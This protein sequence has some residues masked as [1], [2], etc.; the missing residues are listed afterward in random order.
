MNGMWMRIARRHAGA[1]VAAMPVAWRAFGW[2]NG[3]NNAGQAR[4]GSLM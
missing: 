1:A 3:G 2:A 4:R